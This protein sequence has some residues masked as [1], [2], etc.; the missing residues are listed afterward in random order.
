MYSNSRR[1]Y[2][3]GVN[4]NSNYNNGLYSS[5]YN[6]GLSS[7]TVVPVG[8]VQYVP[9]SSL[10]TSTIATP[11]YTTGSQV[12]ATAAPVRATPV[13]YGATPT[14]ASNVYAAPVNTYGYNSAL[15]RAR[16][17]RKKKSGCC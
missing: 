14:Y 8:P 7:S 3:N 6:N 15:P 13:V 16:M 4:Y 17:Y 12:Y 11:T 5:T 9:A 1:Y 10:N 2:G